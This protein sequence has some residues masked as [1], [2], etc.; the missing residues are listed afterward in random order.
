M[1]V[2]FCDQNLRRIEIDADFTGG[3]APEAIRGFRRVMQ[4]IRA[5]TDERDLRAMRSRNFEKLKG[6]RSHEYSMRLN[7]QWRL[8]FE[9]IAGTPKNTLA[10]KNIEDYH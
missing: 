4:A 5:A 7:G 8:V 6:D 1:E 2:Q 3:Y 10:I 9:I